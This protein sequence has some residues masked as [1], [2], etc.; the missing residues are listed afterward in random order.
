MQLKTRVLSLMLAGSMAVSLLPV[1][2]FAAGEAD[3]S[4]TPPPDSFF[5]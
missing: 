1:P 4:T 3:Q 5:R 2:A